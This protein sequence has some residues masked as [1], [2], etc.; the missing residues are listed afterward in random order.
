MFK[1]LMIIPLFGLLIFTGLINSSIAGHHY[2][3]CSYMG[4]ISAMDSNEDGLITFDEFSAPHMEKYKRVF[5]LLDADSNEVI[6][7]EE[8]DEFN[9]IHGFDKNL[10]S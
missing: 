1:K 7:E 10:E 2:H 5:D 3:G 8:V 6:S 4:D 9:K